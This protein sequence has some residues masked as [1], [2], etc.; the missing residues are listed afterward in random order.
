MCK[1][2]VDSSQTSLLFNFIDAIIPDNLMLDS[3]FDDDF[4]YILEKPPDVES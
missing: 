2:C 1:T 3:D 4:H